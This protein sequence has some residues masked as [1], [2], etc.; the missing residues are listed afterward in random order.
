MS[1]TVLYFRSQTKA[2]LPST[3]LESRPLQ[4][5]DRVSKSIFYTGKLMSRRGL[6]LPHRLRRATLTLPREGLRSVPPGPLAV[7]SRQL[8]STE[9]K[10]MRGQIHGTVVY[11]RCLEKGIA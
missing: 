4:P 10:F 1:L 9:E 11:C 3:V 5:Q 6:T 7:S 8:L 2:S